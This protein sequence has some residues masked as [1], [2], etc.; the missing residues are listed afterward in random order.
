MMN[1]EE[2]LPVFHSTLVQVLSELS[3]YKWELIYVDDGSSDGT[4]RVARTLQN[5]DARLRVLRLSRNFGSYAAIRAGFERATGDAVVSISADLQDHPS[6]IAK[7]VAEWEAGFD[8]VWGVR[9]SRD[10]GWSKQWLAK[11]F[12]LLLRKLALKDL[13]L[14]GMDCGLFNRR[15]VQ[16]FLSIPDKNNIPFMTIFWMGFLQKQVLY[17]REARRWGESKWPLGKRIRCALDVITSFSPAPIRYVS[18]LGLGLSF[19]GLAFASH[20][21]F[22]KVI[23]GVGIGGYPSLMVAILVIGGVQLIMLGVLGEY[24]WRVS[25]EVRGRP[26]FIVMDDYSVAAAKDPRTN[27][28]G[29]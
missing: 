25:S 3:A 17:H 9:G 12:Y 27:S 19:A 4:L 6:I 20:I 15:V 29:T 26:D 22:N 14:N 8:V 16:A 13:P 23:Y 2:T 5:E 1:E 24:L 18:Y 10:D 28:I 11:A 7:F 21:I